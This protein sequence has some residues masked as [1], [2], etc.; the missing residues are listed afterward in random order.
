MPK[1][2]TSSIK[3]FFSNW[4]AGNER[5]TCYH[6]GE[7]SK[8]NVTLYIDFDG[9]IRP[10]C[11]YGCAAILNTVDELGIHEEYL[12]NKIQIPNR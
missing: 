1:Q 8:K 9:A 6:C 12:A 4:T 10:V 2:L 7:K 11:C 5:I 3:I